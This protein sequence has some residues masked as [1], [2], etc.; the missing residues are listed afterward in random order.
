[1][2]IHG[3]LFL[4]IKFAQIWPIP[5]SE[6]FHA[7][8]CSRVEKGGRFRSGVVRDC[9]VTEVFEETEW[10]E[11][12]FSGSGFGFDDFVTGWL[13]RSQEAIVESAKRVNKGVEIRDADGDLWGG[14]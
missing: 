14:G 12:G 13:G 6:L 11:E 2:K 7:L 9:D 3:L 5:E 10:G 1:M 8:A 4:L